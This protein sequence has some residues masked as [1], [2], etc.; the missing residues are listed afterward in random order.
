[1]ST[2]DDTNRLNAVDSDVD[3]V[4]EDAPGCPICDVKS[5]ECGH[6]A[7]TFVP[8]EGL[9]GGP[10]YEDAKAFLEALDQAL[11][12]SAKTGRPR[13]KGLCRGLCLEA[14]KLGRR[15]EDRVAPEDV[16][17]ELDLERWELLEEVL[18]HARG[19]EVRDYVQ[20]YGGFAAEDSGRA[21]WAVHVERVVERLQ[22]ETEALEG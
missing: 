11:I 10:A 20:G 19:A 6:L 7:L 3:L 2:D 5:L 4:S 13:V 16:P 1:M 18:D 12:R 21:V 15:R 22:E 17:A 14:A 9:G 8:G